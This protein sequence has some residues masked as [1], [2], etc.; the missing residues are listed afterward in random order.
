M[1]R[2]G[3]VLLKSSF[4]KATCS[5]CL[6]PFRYSFSIEGTMQTIALLGSIFLLHASFVESVIIFKFY[7][8][9]KVKLLCVLHIFF[10]IGDYF[11]IGVALSN[12]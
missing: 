2:A 10:Y 1:L 5:S 7:C 11:T 3:L 6:V 8:L 12:D 9:K 4:D